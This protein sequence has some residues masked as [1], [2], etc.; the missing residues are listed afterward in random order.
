[1][2]VFYQIK[3]EKTGRV[4]PFNENTL[5]QAIK[6]TSNRSKKTCNRLID[7]WEKLHEQKFDFKLLEG[8]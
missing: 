1:M 8:L 7:V 3:N 5:L 2:V 6:Y 4:V